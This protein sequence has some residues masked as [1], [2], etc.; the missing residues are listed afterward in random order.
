MKTE[1]PAPLVELK[2]VRT[3]YPI[4]KGLFFRDTEYVKAVDGVSFRIFPHQTL[5]LVGESGCGKSTLGRSIIGLEKITSGRVY[6]EGTDISHYTQKQMRDVWKRMQII[7][8]DPY[9]SLNPRKSVENMMEEILRIHRI[10]PPETIGS[11]IDRILGLIG[12]LP[13]AKKR[14]PHEFSGGQRQ[15]ISIAKAI[16]LRPRFLI[17]DE[18]TSGLDVSIQAQILTLFKELRAKLGLTSLFISHSLGA[19]KYISDMIGV[20]YLGKIVELGP[21]AEIFRNPRHPYTQALLSAYPDPNPLN[22]GREKILLGGTVPSSANPPGGCG[23][24]PRC[25]FRESICSEQEPEPADDTGH[26]S[27]CHFTIRLSDWRY[28]QAV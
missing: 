9:S 17:C 28:S 10:V 27:A 13:D 23:F 18:A 3:Y 22:R 5:G 20:M 26:R 19:V 14:F 16:T 11:E 1:S 8:Q 4:K 15:R 12:L 21:S 24:H 6:F 7:F 2:Q 25:P